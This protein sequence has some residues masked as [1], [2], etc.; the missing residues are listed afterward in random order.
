MEKV[1]TGEIVQLKAKSKH[2]KDRIH[3]QGDKWLI[4]AITESVLFD[5]KKGIWL[6]LSAISKHDMGFRWVHLT[7]DEHF[8]VIRSEKK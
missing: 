8:E 4:E 1:K 3:Q 2:A 6:G 5:S 7:D